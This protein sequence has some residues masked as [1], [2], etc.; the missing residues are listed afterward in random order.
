MRKGD[1]NRLIDSILHKR[2]RKQ[3]ALWILDFLGHCVVERDL[4]KSIKK[5]IRFYTKE[6]IGKV[7]KG[8][9]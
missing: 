8:V 7:E 2:A 4:K 3:P 5:A 6:F 1:L 9:H